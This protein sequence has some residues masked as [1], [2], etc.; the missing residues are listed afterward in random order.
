MGARELG[1]LRG[2]LISLMPQNPAT[3]LNPV[4]KNHIQVTEI[5]EQHGNKKERWLTEGN[6]RYEQTASK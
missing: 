6:V 1:E 2:K 3:S 5:F 4:L